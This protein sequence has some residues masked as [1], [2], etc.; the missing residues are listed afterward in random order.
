MGAAAAATGPEAGPAVESG[1]PSG[2]DPGVD[3]GP[4]TALRDLR[5]QFEAVRAL[6]AGVGE[7]ELELPTPAAGWTVRH[8]IG[9]LADT[10]EV[11]ADTVTGGPRSF[12]E[13]LRPYPDAAAFTAAGAARGAGRGRDELVA[14]LC[15]AQEAT[16]AALAGAGPR[17][18][19]PWG[20]GLSVGAF[21]Q[22]RLM[23]SWAHGWDLGRALGT[24]DRL[25]A[26]AWHVA[27]LG[28]DTLRFALLRARVRTPP[29]HTLRLDLDAG[30]LGRWTF[31]PAEATDVVS[32]PAEA[33]VRTVTRRAAAEARER[34]RVDG[35]LARLAVAHA[36][37][38]L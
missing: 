25:T 32:G 22:A 7:R 6:L 14:W 36:Q 34:L 19:V 31:G 4:G 26:E 15:R 3:P 21:T 17:A 28:H 35:P 8:Q 13:A 29:G 9:H 11:A 2:L 30:P 24:P 18:R 20:L 12:A 33:W 16:L 38:Y 5:R 27:S 23:E 1:A 37:A 10:E